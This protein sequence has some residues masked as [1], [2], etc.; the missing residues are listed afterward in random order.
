MLAGSGTKH[1]D[2]EQLKGYLVYGDGRFEYG[3]ME[4]HFDTSEVTV[5]GVRAHIG[6]NTPSF[7]RTMQDAVEHLQLLART[8][9]EIIKQLAAEADR[10]SGN[11][12][13]LERTINGQ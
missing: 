13:H 2:M 3:T 9:Y 8:K 11:A 12:R 6:T 1:N 10:C 4:Y 5:N 7:C